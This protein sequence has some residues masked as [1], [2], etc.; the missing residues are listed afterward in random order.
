VCIFLRSK[1]IKIE[2]HVNLASDNAIHFLF[3]IYLICSSSVLDP[4][5]F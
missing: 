2:I 5:G 1:I 4:H 3:S